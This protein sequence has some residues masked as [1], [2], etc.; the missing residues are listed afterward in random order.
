MKTKIM[1][2]P[3]ETGDKVVVKPIFNGVKRIEEFVHAEDTFYTD[4]T[5]DF[6]VN[7]DDYDE[8]Q[9]AEIVGINPG[10]KVIIKV[11]D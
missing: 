8:P 1:C 3:I 9:T 5:H 2:R 6:Y 10:N 4:D 7:M 11:S